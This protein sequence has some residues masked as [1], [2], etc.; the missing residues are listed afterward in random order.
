MIV[1]S[2]TQLRLLMFSTFFSIASQTKINIKYSHKHFSDFLKNRT[3]NYFLSPTDK[4][5][6][7]LIISSLYSTKSVGPNTIPTKILKLLKNDTSY[8]LRVSSN[9][10]R[11]GAPPPSHAFFLT[12]PSKPM[13]PH[14]V[15]SSP[16]LKNEA[17]PTEKQSPLKSIEK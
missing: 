5:E 4:D 13:P 12:P 9:E 10:E 2:Q 3:Q 11:G 16:P 6:I 14:G 15:P 8:Q 17:P 1:L 7:T